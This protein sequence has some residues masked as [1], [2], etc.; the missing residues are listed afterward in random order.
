[1]HRAHYEPAEEGEAVEATTMSS[2][3]SKHIF[4]PG[5]ILPMVQARTIRESLAARDRYS[6]DS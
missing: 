1:M 6:L 5:A 4:A 2:D 3:T